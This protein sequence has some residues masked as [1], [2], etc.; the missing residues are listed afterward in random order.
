[1]TRG[2]G[3]GLT[4]A[5]AI[6]KKKPVMVPKASAYLDFTNEESSF[7]VDGFWEPCHSSPELHSD[8][9]WFEPSV[10][11]ARLQLRKAYNLWK[12]GKL[13]QFGQEAQDWLNSCGFSEEKVGK[14]FYSILLEECKELQ[15]VAQDMFPN[16]SESVF[17][18]KIAS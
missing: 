17:K 3:F 16:K 13:S 2:E 10:N 9:D 8:L 6:D 4:V 12:K 14:D 11:S 5:E 7:Y 1:M 18:E 15:P